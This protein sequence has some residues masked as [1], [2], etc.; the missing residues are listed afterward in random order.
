MYTRLK[1]WLYHDNRP[2]W[3]AR[4]LNK[5]WQWVHSSG[6][7][8]NYLVTLEVI[9]RKS[10]RTIPLPV[11]VAFVD[12]QRYLV[13]MLGNEAQWVQNIHASDGKAYIR[14]GRRTEVHLEEVPVAQRAPILKNY[15]Q[16]A[17]GARP[18]I[19]VNKDAP[20]AEFEAIA[21]SFPAFR[22]VPITS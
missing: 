1:E 5:F 14:S 21:S 7:M 3:L 17:P 22:I 18:H 15:L 8:P 19:P 6:I 10:G 4:I 20:L 9:G 13:S 11:V 16:R 2:N 12:G